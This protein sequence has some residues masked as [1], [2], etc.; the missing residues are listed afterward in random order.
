MGRVWHASSQIDLYITSI[1]HNIIQV[2]SSVLW[3]WHYSTKYSSYSACVWRMFCEILSLSQNIVMDQN[4]DMFSF[5]FE[6]LPNH[7][8]NQPNQVGVLKLHLAWTTSLCRSEYN[9]LW[10]YYNVGSLGGVVIG[11]CFHLL[12]WSRMVI[13][14]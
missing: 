8:C 12:H 1:S 2:R 6:I 13:S 11:I 10:E 5:V 3:D 7:G 9:P 4:N 14:S